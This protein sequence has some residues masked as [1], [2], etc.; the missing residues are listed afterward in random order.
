MVKKIKKFKPEIVAVEELF[1]YKNITTAIKVG[2]AR[3]VILLAAKKARVPVRE[4]TPLQV[5]QAI[6]G[7][8]KADKTQVQKM[9]RAL[10]NLR[11]IPRP[12]DAADALAIAICA[13]SN[14]LCRFPN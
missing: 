6:S 5:K 14:N 7:Y 9:V 10:L 2:H 8:G 12:D 1:F 13:A 3:G 4:F 11:E